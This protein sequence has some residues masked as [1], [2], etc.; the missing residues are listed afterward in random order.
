MDIPLRTCTDSEMRQELSY[1]EEVE[2]ARWQDL[3]NYL[4][5]MG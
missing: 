4:Y 1:R 3:A 2:L 5:M